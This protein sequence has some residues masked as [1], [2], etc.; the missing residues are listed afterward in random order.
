MKRCIFIVL[1]VAC[2]GLIDPVQA[3]GARNSF[4]DGSLIQA[5]DPDQYL[6]ADLSTNISAQMQ[7]AKVPGLSIA[8]IEDGKIVWVEGFGEANLI[9]GKPVTEDTIFDVASISK[10]ITAYAALGLVERGVLSLDEPVHQY[11]SQAWL[12][13][14]AYA[15]Q[16]TLRQLLSHTSGLTNAVNPVNKTIVNPPGERFEYSGVGFIYLQEVMEQATGKSL[17]QLAQE[18]VFEPLEMDSSSY[19]VPQNMMPR[20]ANGHIHYGLFLQL[21]VLVLL[22]VFIL[23]L[24]VISIIQRIRLGKFSLSGKMVA[25]AY[26]IAASFALVAVIYVGNGVS[27]W[28]T[29]TA[30]WLILFGGGMALLLFAGTKLIR[31]LP[32]RLQE[33]KP[34]SALLVLWSVIS[35]LAL[36]YLTFVLSGPVPRSPAGPPSAA[37]SLRTTAPD[38]AKFLIELTS[39]QHLDPALMTEMTSPQVQIENDQSWGLGMAILH[40][41]QG[42]LLWHDG[43][44]PDFHAWMGIDQG[45]MDGVVVLTNGENGAPLANEIA[46]FALD[47]ISG[48]D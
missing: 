23:T 31:R 20:L 27:K 15:E 22:G 42:D 14:S 24:L 16:I 1:M 6:V 7:A 12:P 11:L 39:P 37:F 13:A 2:L 19:V 48:Q 34:R 35:A 10:A 44:N 46:N 8:L 25:L 21:L 40:S 28:V 18:L 26:L 33:P 30:L 47:T 9:T 32:G 41:S 5:I 3:T 4:G 29:L 38:L 43:N 36:L 17:E 45:Q